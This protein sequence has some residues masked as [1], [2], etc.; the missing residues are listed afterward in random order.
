MKRCL[1]LGVALAAVVALLWPVRSQAGAISFNIMRGQDYTTGGGASPQSNGMV[2]ADVAGAP[3]VHVGNWNNIFAD[4]RNDNVLIPPPP[5]GLSNNETSGPYAGNWTTAYGNPVDDGGNAVAGMD[6]SWYLRGGTGQGFLG[7]SGW[8][9]SDPD[10]RMMSSNWD[11]WG[12]NGDTAGTPPLTGSN[13]SDFFVTGIPYDNYDLYA[14][15]L[16]ETGT[17]GGDW[18][19]N[20]VTKAI[21]YIG[22]RA[23]DPLYVLVDY[24][25]A[26]N[27]AAQAT[28]ELKGTYLVIEGL[29]GDLTLST[30]AHARMRISGFQ[31][32]EVETDIIPEPSTLCLAAL[33]L[34]GLRR[35]MRRRRQTQGAPT[36]R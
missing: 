9:T 5:P 29:S 11:A 15:I 33:G 24:D 3:G 4:F 14:Y 31:I 2:P 36:T 27:A 35:R 8:S 30:T 10:H 16:A 13:H 18:T 25:G 1:V 21:E 7:Y 6:V 22:E 32:V 28:G 17:H 34:L 23:P 12:R 19:A 26:W 20:G